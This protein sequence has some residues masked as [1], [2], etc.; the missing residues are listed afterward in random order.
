MKFKDITWDVDEE[1]YRA[2]PSFHYSMLSRYAKE[3]FKC[4][5]NIR[6]FSEKTPSL[7]FGSVVDCLIT[8]GENEFNKR[9][10]ILDYKISDTLKQITEQIYNR[11]FIVYKSIED[12]PD[13]KILESIEEIE[14]YNNLKPEKR[15]EKIKT[16]C[17]DYY[18]ELVNVNGR[19]VINRETY[20]DA[21]KTVESLKEYS[22]L[23]TIFFNNPF[24]ENNEILFQAK[25]REE[26]CGM[27]FKCMFDILHIDHAN[28]I[29][30]PI[31]LK[32]SSVEEYCFS[33]EFIKWKYYLQAWLYK[34]ILVKYIKNTEFKDYYVSDFIF[35]VINK[36]SLIP[37]IYD[38]HVPCS[39]DS[40]SEDITLQ[41]NKNSITLES[42]I[43]LAKEI[44]YYESSNSVCPIGIVQ[45]IP[46]NLNELILKE[47]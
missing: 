10:Y 32:T 11:N 5:K 1:T 34:S 16:G 39:E 2:D 26:L 4:I 30:Y 44:H 25:F 40:L 12:I 43:R 33:K 41:C 8:G 35:I 31:D 47:F 20:D 45:S 38:F 42:P 29:I 17:K 13:D 9:F 21:V 7:I 19:C 3:G 36:D 23:K 37:L 46:N 27:T 22:L 14:Y 24:D 28:K 15:V 6:D 18:I